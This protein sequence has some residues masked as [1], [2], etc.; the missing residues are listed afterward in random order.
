VVEDGPHDRKGRQ[1]RDGQELCPAGDERPSRHRDADARS[2]NEDETFYVLDGE[3]VALVGDER[4]TLSAGDFA[5]APRGVPHATVVSSERA[6]VLVTTSPGGLEELFVSLGS[7]VSASEP[8]GRAGAAA[9]ARA[10][11]PLRGLRRR[12]RR[13]P[14]SLSDLGI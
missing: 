4:I 12:H 8:P 9:D 3:I 13:P 6:G 1:R 2:H 5:F 11:T 7:T 14:P 10:R